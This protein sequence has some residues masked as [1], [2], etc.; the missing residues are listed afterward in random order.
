MADKNHGKEIAFAET[1]EEETKNAIEKTFLKYGVS[2]LIKVD[3]VHDRKKGLFESHKKYSFYINRYQEE[4][5]KAAMLAAQID[6]KNI[7][8]L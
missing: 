7:V 4:E 3:K 1:L 2:Y 5:A 6:D 8:Y